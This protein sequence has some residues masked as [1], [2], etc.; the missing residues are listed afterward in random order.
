MGKGFKIFLVLA[1][2]LGVM[3]ACG[4]KVAR[5][6][7]LV[8]LLQTDKEFSEFSVENGA[9]EAFKKYLMEKA[10]QLPVGQ[11]PIQGRNNIYE[12]MLQSGSDYTLSWKPQ[13]G[14][15]ALSR[16]MGYTWGVYTLSV[17]NDAG[18]IQKQTGKYLNVW[19]KDN[20]GKW[21]VIIDMGNQNSN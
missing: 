17:Q 18:D 15:V 3:L 21:R 16:D 6:K 11:N 5:E 2:L 13:N 19:K 8:H 7:E 14:E 9:A 20:A 12:E 10:V 1:C 4:K